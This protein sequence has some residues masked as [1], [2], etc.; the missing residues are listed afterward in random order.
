[1]MML[2]MALYKWGV[3]SAQRSNKFYT[4]MILIG[5][6]AGYAIIAVGVSQNF[7]HDW[8]MD[9][10]MFIGNQFNYIGSIL[11]ALG[12]IGIIMLICKSDRLIR[13]KN[14]FASVGKM[15]FT[16]YILM[17][18]IAMFIFYGNG[19]G[20]FGQVERSVQILIVI[21]IWVIILII[22]P[23]WLKKFR[24]GPLEWLWRVLSYWR[25][26]PMKIIN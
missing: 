3:L 22:S 9:Y 21:A 17:S 25:K 11:V 19:L 20:L 15:A 13:F 18:L 10:S 8:S 4:K 14:L 16:N 7:Q 24:Y 5:L 26:Q 6:V 1:M 23:L 12:Y 2:G